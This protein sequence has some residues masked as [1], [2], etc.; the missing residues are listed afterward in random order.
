MRRN[1]TNRPRRSG[2]NVKSTRS[3]A[4]AG[5]RRRIQPLGGLGEC[6]VRAAV[7]GRG[8]RDWSGRGAI[9]YRGD[10]ASFSTRR[11]IGRLAAVLAPALRSWR[12]RRS[13]DEVRPGKDQRHSL[14]GDD[15]ALSCRAAAVSLVRRQ[16]PVGIRL[17]RR[18]G[19]VQNVNSAASGCSR[20][21][22][23]SID[24]VG[25]PTTPLATIANSIRRKR[26]LAP[27]PKRS[28]I[29]SAPAPPNL[30]ACG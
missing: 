6:A 20:R 23:Q 29:V 18:A 9:Q 13:D 14:A 4:A 5:W 3:W 27:A 8:S 26:R 2:Q 10:V 19:A 30:Q 16:F 25:R 24:D 11:R 22:V 28:P 17:Q 21:A 7:S 1:S 12:R 15:G